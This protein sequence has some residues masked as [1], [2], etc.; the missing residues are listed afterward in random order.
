[1]K[2]ILRNAGVLLPESKI[3]FPNLDVL[4]GQKILIQGDSGA[5]KSTL[6][7]VILGFERLSFGELMIND[8]NV[9]DE[10]FWQLRRKIAY[11][12]QDISLPP[13]KAY[14][15]FLFLF[16]FKANRPAE[17][18]KD[19]VGRWFDF[20][21]LPL[22]ILEKNIGNL[23]GGERQRLGLISAILLNRKAFILDEPTSF[24]NKP[25]KSKASGLF[26]NRSDWTVLVCSHDSEWMR[27][28][29]DV[30]PF[31]SSKAGGK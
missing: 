2:I 19:I 5:G 6:F 9:S 18:S 13:M 7:K 11:V 23:S 22:N 28:G 14:D 29:V 12:D 25:L 24:L 8:A 10:D 1:M 20:F 16:S 4:N 15:W 26:L 31:L 21:Q 30:V 27:E 17:F 3:K